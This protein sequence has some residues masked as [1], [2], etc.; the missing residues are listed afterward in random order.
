MPIKLT[1][2][3]AAL[4]AVCFLLFRLCIVVVIQIGVFGVRLVSKHDVAIDGEH[5]LGNLKTF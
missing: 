2:D 5:V 1:Y 3:P 4:R